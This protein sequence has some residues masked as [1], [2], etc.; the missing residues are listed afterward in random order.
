MNEDL[1]LRSTANSTALVIGDQV[2]FQALFADARPFVFTKAQMEFLFSLQETKSIET[3]CAVVNK[4]PEWAKLF[5]SS[6]KFRTFRNAKLQEASVKNGIT[7]EWWYQ[8]GKEISQGYVE[9]Y[10]GEC[11]MCH[12][13]PIFTVYEAESFRQDDMSIKAQCPVCFIAIAI[14]LKHEDF[15]PTR[16]QVVAWQELGARLVPKI[17]RVQ[18]EF[19][20]EN[21]VFESSESA[22]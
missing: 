21:F 19:A 14:E 18:H 9:C 2:F 8:F 22:A 5:L 17:E 3:A 13:K 6:R 11:S 7:I 20:K 4:S 15:T 12:E 16:E 10:S 1:S